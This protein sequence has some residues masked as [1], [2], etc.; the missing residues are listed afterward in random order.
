MLGPMKGRVL[1]TGT[2]TF[3]F[4]DMEGSTRLVQGVGPAAFKRV[5]ERHNEIL[6]AAFEAHGGIERGT[7]GDSFLVMFAEAPAAVAA[8]AE[9]QTSFAA[10]AWPDGIDVRVRIG[11]HTGVGTLGGDDYVGVDV[12]RAA[13]MAAAAH[14]GQVLLSDATRA[15]TALAM[16]PRVGLRDL[17]EHKL[18]DLARPERLF[19]LVLA[20]VPTD[21]GPLRTGERKVGNLPPRLTSFLGREADLEALRKLL[22]SNRLVTLTGAGGSGKTS[23]AIEVARASEADFP[24]GA[25]FV[26]LDA[27]A[28]PDLVES[29]IATSLGLI[30]SPGLSAM[31]RLISFLGDR[32][33][34]LVVDNFEQVLAAAPFLGELTQAAGGLTMLV[35]S[36][37]RLRLSIEQ[38]FPIAPL[39]VPG[40]V[41]PVE[42]A[43][44]SPAVRLFVDRARRVR[45]DFEL[46]SSD[47]PAVA[48]IC[49]R[50]DGLPLGIE[51]AAS[52]I[53]LLTP[54]SIAGRLAQRLDLPG[55]AP[56]DMPERQ[57]SLERAIA[58]SHD[59][60]EP[61]EQRLL[62]RLSVFAGGSRLEE[63]EAVCGPSTE[64][65]IDVI[66]GISQLVDHGLLQPVPGSDGARYR[67][68]ETVRMF[69][70]E[71][72]GEGPDRA[73]IE[74]R[75]AVAYLELAEEAASHMMARGQAIWLDRL[76]AERDNLRAAVQWSI[77][78]REAEIALRLGAACWRFWQQRGHIVEGLATID[79]V[80]SLPG[81]EAPSLA[82]VRALDAAGGLRWWTADA[83]AADAFYR[84]QLALAR[85]LSDKQA[86]ADAISNVLFPATVLHRDGEELDRLQREAS[87]L[88]AE[89][90]DERG[91]ERVRLGLG[92]V[93]QTLMNPDASLATDVML[94]YL[95]RF[96]AFDDQA[97]VALTALALTAISFRNGDREAALRWGLRNI[98]SSMVMGD[99]NSAAVGLRLAS[100]VLLSMGRKRE[101]ALTN[102]AFE[103]LCARYAIR[104]PV[105][106]EEWGSMATPEASAILHSD[107]Y[108]V[109]ARRGAKM[110]IEEAVD[111]LRRLVEDDFATSPEPAAPAAAPTTSGRFIREGDV[112][113]ITY[114]DRTFRIRDT[115]GLRY[116]AD[117]LA[118]P[119]R[120]VPAIDLAATSGSGPRAIAAGVAAEAGLAPVVRTTDPL[121]D[122]AARGAYRDRLRDLQEEIDEAERFGDGERA[123]R[124]REE[125][126][127]LARE[128][129][130]ATG[131]GGRDRRAPSDAERA[132]QSV[133]KAI[134]QTLDRIEKHDRALAAHLRHSIRLG[135]LCG[136]LP[137]P[138]SEVRWTT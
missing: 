54:Q 133:S 79:A 87:A 72:L 108:A 93:F 98:E 119:R 11:L 57:R 49:T 102:A 25:W 95:A 107:A 74:R 45:P 137:D 30:E 114:E 88:Y 33:V 66:E 59:L 13:R 9:A 113:A 77:V 34:L 69:A 53:G 27:V 18:K 84:A 50:L 44:G 121:L 61:A 112:W 117:L 2:V 3:L 40:P 5:L 58:W 31:E 70:R 42:E 81:A 32:H 90:G 20:D 60:L 8:A 63:A 62:A 124:A 64:L 91:L 128:L 101:G 41:D 71:R 135:A 103:A 29:S 99:V 55:P 75:H 100:V 24:D 65:G 110:T 82:R 43:M 67:L 129:T 109:D 125:F 115:K 126:E 51:L 48:E 104:P 89:I 134:R 116:L 14:G 94:D 4:S 28:D 22:R 38:E 39:A 76:T 92:T 16:P 35:T 1:P 19:E 130:V 136:Y 36:R 21:F 83:P 138:R 96:E 10:E 78:E 123:S 6:R 122:S 131:L 15:L 80:L 86:I 26:P 68:L 12:N 37:A 46:T 73:A 111:Y 132:R 105:D 106:P 120:E 85:E 97:Y 7:Q 23:L 127:F 17:G 47:A 52:R 56:R 118:A